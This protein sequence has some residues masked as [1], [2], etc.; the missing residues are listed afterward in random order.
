MPF[1]IMEYIKGSSLFEAIDGHPIEPLQAAEITLQVCN[2]L[3]HAHEEDILHRDIKPE[4]IMLAPGCNAKIADFGLARDQFNPE[5]EEVIW[6]SPGYVAPEVVMNPEQV[7]QRSDV[8]SV[9][10]VLYAMLTGAPPNPNML[11]LN[12][13]AWCDFRFTY[14]IQRSMAHSQEQRYASCKE[15][16]GDLSLLID[17][18]KRHN[19][20][21]AA[22]MVPQAVQAVQA[23]P[24]HP[25]PD[26]SQLLQQP[27]SDGSMGPQKDL[28]QAVEEEEE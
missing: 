23:T 27:D 1:I 14:L 20:T 19:S 28:K 11:D 16:A 17:S 21:G 6:G 12:K 10:C 15:F 18:L 5:K 3:S 8:Y 9:G 22:P 13:L 26:Q 7:D 4:N 24:A 2:G 25:A